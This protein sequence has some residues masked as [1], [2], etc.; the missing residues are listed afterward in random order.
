MANKN[1]VIHWFRKGLRLHDNP[2]LLEAVEEATKNKFYLRP[3]F[4]LDPNILKWLKVGANRWR[5]LQES[6]SDLNDNLKKIGSRLYVVRGEPKEVFVRIFKEWKVKYLSFELDIE[7]YAKQ[8]DK[9][10]ENIAK[11][12]DVTVVQRV[13]HTLYD[14]E[15]VVRKNLGKPPLTYQRFLSVAESLGKIS[16]PI[17]LPKA[18]ATFSIPLAD[19]LESKNPMCYDPPTLQELG[20]KDE[21]LGENKFPGGETEALKRLEKYMK[22]KNWVC[23][24]E[25]P[26]TSPNSIEPSTTVLSPYLKFGC[27][28]CRTFYQK[29]KETIGNSPHSKPPVSLIG[30]LMWREF[31]YCVGDSTPNYDK[32][33]GNPICYQI[34]W[35]EN[36][37]YFLAWKLGKTG[38]PFI[39]AIMRQLRLEGLFNV[40]FFRW[41]Q[42]KFCLFVFGS[43]KFLVISNINA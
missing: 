14:T 11:S 20:V 22:M 30:Q 27:L 7:P 15:Q 23:K 13:S 43:F 25:K 6:L 31:Y 3:I 26:N 18:V 4:I 2:A 32:M 34:P 28:S 17:S 19:N 21:E 8:R 12:F 37:E 36:E 5:F 35:T 33:V 9:Q 42:C 38:Y 40:F 41:L 24:F 29:L 10:I 16:A 39:D 1:T